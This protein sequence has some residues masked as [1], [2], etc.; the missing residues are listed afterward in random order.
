[1]AVF[2]SRRFRRTTTAASPL[3]ERIGAWYRRQVPRH[4]FLLFGL[5]FLTMIVGGSFA[6]TP[7][8]AIRYERHDRR[9][10][11][12]S[13]E[14][15]LELGLKGPDGESNIER[16]PRRRVVGSERDEYYVSGHERLFFSIGKTAAS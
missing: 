13:Q 14:E 1:M 3:T 9:V 10:R 7:A 6:L 4:P 12:V 16:N 11:Q 2:P 15:A 5:P 8:T